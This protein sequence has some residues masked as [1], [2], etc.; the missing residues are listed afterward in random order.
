MLA[1]SLETHCWKP[2]D[3][4]F[5]TITARRNPNLILLTVATLAGAAELGMPMVA[6]WTL[7]SIVFH[8]VRLGQAFVARAR[9]E[10]I[11]PWDEDPAPAPRPIA[12]PDSEIE[13]PA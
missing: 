6:I 7:V 8:C 13:R 12:R 3:T 5:R 11:S 10:T 1:F 9:G 2:I 4:L